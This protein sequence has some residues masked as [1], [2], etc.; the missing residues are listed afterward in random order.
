MQANSHQ[1]KLQSRYSVV[2]TLARQ[3]RGAWG[4]MVCGGLCLGLGPSGNQAS[5][6]G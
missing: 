1:K 5:K 3:E 2:L 6:V 4:V